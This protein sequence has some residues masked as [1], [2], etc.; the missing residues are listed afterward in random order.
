MKPAAF[1]YL[2]PRSRAEAIAALASYGGEAKLLAGGQS[3]VPLLNFRLLRPAA[4]IDINRVSGLDHVDWRADTG[5]RIGVRQASA[6]SAAIADGEVGDM[7]HGGG[8][9]GKM[10]GH[11]GGHFERVVPRERTDP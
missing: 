7:S 10:P 4:L 9:D 5:L 1:A 11:D 3:L 6:D 2:Q 8:N